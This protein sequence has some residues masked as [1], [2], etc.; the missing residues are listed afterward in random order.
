MSNCY[1]NDGDIASLCA[2][3]EDIGT[4]KIRAVLEKSNGDVDRAA[5]NL[6]SYQFLFEQGEV[7]KGIDGFA[8]MVDEGAATARMNKVSKR[9][10]Q[11]KP[12]PGKIYMPH[13]PTTTASQMSAVSP[14]RTWAGVA[15]VTPL[16]SPTNSAP[17]G[18]DGRASPTGDSSRSVG[19]NTPSEDMG[20]YI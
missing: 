8:A 14:T 2:M 5:E 10:Q 4:D 13:M 15:S 12:K 7:P 17:N 6:L 20:V 3:F 18:I 19:S 1:N 16:V 11:K 9:K